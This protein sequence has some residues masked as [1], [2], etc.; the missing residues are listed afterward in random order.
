MQDDHALDFLF[1]ENPV[2]H[3]DD[4][5]EMEEAFSKPCCDC[6]DEN[7]MVADALAETFPF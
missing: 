3:Y 4:F 7:I 2:G 1:D 6:Q 5:L